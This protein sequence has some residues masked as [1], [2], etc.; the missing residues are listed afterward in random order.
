MR[1]LL[2]ATRSRMTLGGHRADLD[3]AIPRSYTMGSNIIVGYGA[4][5]M[6]G[7]GTARWTWIWPVA[8]MDNPVGYTLPWRRRIYLLSSWSSFVRQQC[9]RLCITRRWLRTALASHLARL[10]LR[11]A[12][13]VI[14]TALIVSVM[15]AAPAEK[16]G[17][18]ARHGF[19]GRHDRMQRHCRCMSTL[20]RR[21]PP[22]TRISGSRSER[23]SGGPCCPNQSHDGSSEPCGPRTWSIVQQAALIFAGSCIA[24]TIFRIRFH[25]D[26]APSRLFSAGQEFELGGTFIAPG[27]QNNCPERNLLLVSLVAIVGLAKV[28]TPTVEQ[29]IDYLQVPKAVVGIIIAALVLLPEAVAAIKAARSDRLQTSLNLALARR[30]RPSV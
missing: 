8:G 20:G 18:G 25:P 11:L 27:Q 22:R 30:S 1:G 6:A 4:M 5:G 26:G 17:T 10:F 28:L 23:G 7:A 15:I 14:E 12:V 29:G 3:V 24:G 2:L 13:T 19:R 9:L 21:P 16:A